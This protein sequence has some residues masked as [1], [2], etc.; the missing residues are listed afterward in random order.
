[1]KY[2]LFDRDGTLIKDPD[3]LRVKSVDEIELFDDTI[4]ALKRLHE[5]SFVVIIVTNQ[6]GISEGKLS[7]LEF[8]EINEQFIRLIEPSGI[9][10]P[11]TYMCPHT[12][13]DECD[14]RK[15]LPKLLCQALED[16]EID[17]KK[18]FMV[19]D[20]RSDIL[21]GR[22]AGVRTILVKT[23][24][25][26]QDEAPEADFE[27]QNLTEAVDIIIREQEG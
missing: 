5:N 16:F 4:S 14:C 26:K 6:A 15:P 21:A 11:T 27:A 18:T 17:P 2:I 9:E 12:A 22:A 13:E 8:D 24:T 23:A 19:G 10:V 3:D 7:A 20:H 1:M 25:G